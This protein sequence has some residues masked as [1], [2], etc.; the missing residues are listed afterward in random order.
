MS[1]LTEPVALAQGS[2]YDPWNMPDSY[3]VFM[4]AP[5]HVRQWLH[6]HWQTQKALHP[7]G[8]YLAG[9]YFL[10]IGDYFCNLRCMQFLKQ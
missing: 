10:V 2:E 5:E 1:N 7:M 4:A 6:P 3:T 8:Y 9:M